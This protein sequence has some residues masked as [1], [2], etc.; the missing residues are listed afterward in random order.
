MRSSRRAR[1]DKKSTPRKKPDRKDKRQTKGTEGK[2]TELC[3]NWARRNLTGEGRGCPDRVTSSGKKCLRRHSFK[4]N[5][6]KEMQKK[7]KKN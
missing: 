2:R 4:G 5:E 7:F 3:H 6:K 1:R